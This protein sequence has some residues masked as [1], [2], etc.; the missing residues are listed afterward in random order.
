MY[1]TSSEILTE[2]Q[3]NFLI[4]LLNKFE[5]EYGR[6][7]NA[8]QESLIFIFQSKHNLTRQQAIERILLQEQK[9]EW[10]NL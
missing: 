10:Y 1:I 9:K 7:D 3:Q 8:L 2:A 6:D 5:R 4:R